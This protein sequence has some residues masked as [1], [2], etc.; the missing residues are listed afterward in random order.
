MDALQVYITHWVVESNRNSRMIYRKRCA[1]SLHRNLMRRKKYILDKTCFAYFDSYCDFVLSICCVPYPTDYYVREN[2]KLV[3]H[4][5]IDPRHLEFISILD[6]NPS[7][8]E[9]IFMR[10]SPIG[11]T[12]EEFQR[13]YPYL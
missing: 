12:F 11:W 6:F 10:Y 3:K 5:Y 13:L 9:K 2:N 4:S 1:T 8:Y 7:P